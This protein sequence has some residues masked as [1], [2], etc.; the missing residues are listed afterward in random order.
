MSINLIMSNEIEFKT[1]SYK[2]IKCV[3]ITLDNTRKISL[4][5]TDL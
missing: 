3:I 4:Y 2:G 1:S 5:T